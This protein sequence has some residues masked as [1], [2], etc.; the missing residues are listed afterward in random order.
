MHQTEQ[1]AMFLLLCVRV[2]VHV[3]VCDQST[4]PYNREVRTFQQYQGRSFH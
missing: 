1:S 3:A 2:F 4:I